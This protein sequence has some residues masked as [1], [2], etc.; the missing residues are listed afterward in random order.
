MDSQDES[1]AADMQSDANS[2]D[3][4]VGAETIEEMQDTMN[5]DT[6][7]P[8]PVSSENFEGSTT[9]TSIGFA[10]PRTVLKRRLRKTKNNVDALVAI[11]KE[12]L[13]LIKTKR[14]NV[15]E[16]KED[17]HQAFF[18][19]L[20]PHVRKIADDN[21]LPFRNTVQD[22]VQRYAYGYNE[23]NQGLQTYN[24]PINENASPY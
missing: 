15:E 23:R 24:Y 14:A 12:K 9:G 4:T 22:L 21:I 13:E 2:D 7:A 19:S 18:N 1:V 20:L 5:V 17:D 6:A 10:E 11:E 16:T 8:S 3:D